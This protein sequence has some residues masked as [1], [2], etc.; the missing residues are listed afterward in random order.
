MRWQLQYFT[1]SYAFNGNSK[2][3]ASN[4]MTAKLVRG[5]SN[6]RAEVMRE[7]IADNLVCV[8]VLRVRVHV[9]EPRWATVKY[10]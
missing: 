4:L 10:D 6:Q 1:S 2:L 5:E 9:C 8:C 7:S 3:H